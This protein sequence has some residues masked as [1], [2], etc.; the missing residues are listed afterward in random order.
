MRA[1][2]A[3]EASHPRT[4]S[5]RLDAFQATESPEPRAAASFVTPKAVCKAILSFQCWAVFDSSAA[6]VQRA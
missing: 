1:E 4:W 5:S 2:L 6:H 3:A